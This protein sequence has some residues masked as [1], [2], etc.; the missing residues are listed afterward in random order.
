M[1]CGHSSAPCRVVARVP[2][3]PDGPSW[4]DSLPGP[5]VDAFSH[6]SFCPGGTRIAATAV[7]RRP[8]K[9][10]EPCGVALGTRPM[11]EMV[12][13][14]FMRAVGHAGGLLDELR[15]FSRLGNKDEVGAIDTF[16]RGFHPLGHEFLG[17]EG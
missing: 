7:R 11:K 13:F 10:R 1:E 9:P 6:R 14:P 12:Q 5:A 8:R 4:L 15:H 3:V 2:Y 16:G 17:L